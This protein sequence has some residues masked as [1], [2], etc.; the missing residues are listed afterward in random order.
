[1]AYSTVPTVATGDLWTAANHNSYI[2][3]NF[4]AGVPDIFTA[5]GD[6]AAATGPNAAIPVVVGTNGQILTADSGQAVGVKWADQAGN[7]AII[8]D[9]WGSV[10]GT[11][12][13]LDIPI[14]FALTITGWDLLANLSGS[15]VIDI[16]KDTYANFP[17]TDADSITAAAPPTISAAIKAQ[18]VTLTGWTKSVAAGSVLRINVDSCATITRVALNL[19]FNRG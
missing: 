3:D 12:I 9:G 1:M 5:K 19:R 11:G 8:L 18:D 15:I 7:L 16:W 10:I 17:P 2:R 13:K 14:S 6:I 4:A